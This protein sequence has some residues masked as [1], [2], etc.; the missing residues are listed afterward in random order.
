[1]TGCTTTPPAVS[2]CSP[3][4]SSNR[5]SGT[6]RRRVTV[7]AGPNTSTGDR[8][9]RHHQRGDD[10]G[11]RRQGLH[12]CPDR[13]TYNNNAPNRAYINGVAVY[14][15]QGNA[16]PTTKMED[17]TTGPGGS[18][19]SA[20]LGA[21]IT[22][23]PI[24][25]AT[26]QATTGLVAPDGI[27]GM[28]PSYPGTPVGATDVMYTE[29]ELSYYVAGTTTSTGSTTFGSSAIQRCV[30]AVALRV[31]GHAVDDLV[32]AAGHGPDGRQHDVELVRAGHLHRPHR[33]RR[34]TR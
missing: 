12:Q 21:P 10:L 7:P 30:H 6:S 2:P 29:K 25:P 33:R 27:V 34:P 19:L 28:L 9:A 14:C 16:N 24:I 18:S 15:D 1:M 5:S 17:C 31:G 11:R 26:A 20:A 8:R 22:S 4:T 13:T 32:L 3:A 23:D